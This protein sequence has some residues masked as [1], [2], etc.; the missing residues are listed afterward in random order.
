MTLP[1]L[2]VLVVSLLVSGF[3]TLAG[4][5]PSSNANV[6][7]EL[8]S[9]NLITISLDIP[10]AELLN[11]S[12]E[13]PYRVASKLY[14]KVTVKND[15]DQR[16]MVRVADRFYQNRPQLFRNGRL[17]PYRGG[18]AE[19]LQRQEEDPQ[20]VS[21]RHVVWVSPYS[22][23]KLTETDLSDWYGQLEPGSYRL[24]SRY[25]LDVRGPWTADSAPLLFQVVAQ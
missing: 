18:L 25:R 22:S 4:Q 6:L 1:T 8:V 24:I 14:V 16:I 20:F 2:K 13:K 11:K 12:G 7:Q 17:V 15:S 23:E 19:S 5:T 21:L 9:A 10:E 3:F